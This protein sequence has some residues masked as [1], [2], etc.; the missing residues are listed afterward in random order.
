M[1]D[2]FKGVVELPKKEFENLWKNSTFIFDTNVLLDLYRLSREGREDWLKALSKISKRFMP[3]QIGFEFHKNRLK[4]IKEEKINNENLITT[5]N[6]EFSDLE[7]SLK[8]F[9][10]IKN[11]VSKIEEIKEIF[12]K[13]IQEEISGYPDFF[14]DD[15]VLNVLHA[16]F[17]DSV[18]PE[19]NQDELRILYKEA[20]ERFKENIPPGFKDQKKIDNSKYG[21]YIIWK[22]VLN[23]SK[24]NTSDVI[25]ITRDEKED[26]WDI[27]KGQKIGPNFY[28]SYEFFK[29]SGRY[30]YQCTPESFLKF[31]KQYIDVTIKENS[32]TETARVSELSN[33]YEKAKRDWDQYLKEFNDL[34]N[35]SNNSW[36]KFLEE[37]KKNAQ[38]N[39]EEDFEMT[40]KR[41]EQILATKKNNNEK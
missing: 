5:I 40:K 38:I 2:T 35:F 19:F 12:F 23:F 36:P 33:F 29:N 15:Q 21:D 14:N 37:R 17:K 32:I 3:Y 6:K 26:W 13:N 30:Y 4:V 34:E 16:V 7:N 28:L 41:L 9:S 10:R 18:G 27:L 1:K 31:F 8:N 24:K 22:Q 20:D 25:F 11:Q 39:N